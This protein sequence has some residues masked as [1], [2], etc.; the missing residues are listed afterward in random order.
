MAQRYQDGHLRR[1]KR[2]RGPDVWEFLWREIGP[3]GGRHQRTLTVGNVHELRTEREA[4]NRIQLLRTNINRDL[5]M[6]SL[7]T[8]KD[9]VDHYRQTELLADNKTEKTRKTYLVYLR[10]WIL[11]IWGKEYLHNI[12]AVRVEH[13][14]RNLMGLSRGSKCKVR[15]IMSG[16]FS[17]AIRYEFADKNPIT[18]VRQ[19]GVRENTPVLLEV[20]ELHRLFDELELRERAMIVCDALTGMRRSELT[21]LQWC[22]LDFLE[23][24]INIVRSVVDQVVGNCK[25]EASR[26]PVVM[27]EHIAQALMA[28]RQEST[29]TAPTDWVWA[30]PQK[31]GKQ[32]LWLATVM[33]YYIQPAAR[34]AGID[35]KIG[36]HTFRHTFSTLIKSLG[37]DAKVVQELLRHAS[38]K[39][40]MDGYTQALEEPKRQAQAA[41]ADLIMRTGTAFHA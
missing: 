38:F 16:I 2:K 29:Y 9:L 30:S 32:P 15:N 41:L 10:N 18:A 34:R 36:W 21:G 13:W 14:L 40:T 23:M 37:V 17:H 7:M 5:P 28:W 24:R 39:T 8:F 3:N 12:K 35:K 31:K 27:N 4:L 19:S 11:P 20:A 33:R 26:K 6:S 1:A 25:T 22:D